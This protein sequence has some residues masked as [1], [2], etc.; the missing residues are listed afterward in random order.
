[1]N[2]S[3]PP[4]EQ[5]HQKLAT[6]VVAAEL[7]QSGDMVTVSGG[8][9]QPFAFLAALSR[10]RDLRRVTV[11]SAMSLL[12]ADL[13][14][15]QF[16]AAASGEAIER[17]VR[18]ASFCVGPGTREGVVSGV[19]DFVPMSLQNL[20][21]ALHDRRLDVVVIGSSGMD[22]EGNF[23]LGCNVDWM[24]EL[25]TSANLAETLVVVEVNS[26]LPRT[27]GTTTFPLRIVDRIVEAPRTPVDLPVGPPLPEAQAVGGFLNA[28]VPDG[29]TLQFG[30]GDLVSQSASLLD[31]KRDLGLHSNLISDVALFLSERGA[32]TG[33]KKKHLPG[34]WVGS[35][36]LGSRKLYEFADDSPVLALHS[37]E[38]VAHPVNI[39]RNDKVVSITQGVRVDLAGQVA[40]QTALMEF[41]SHPG[42]Q[43]V[44]HS[45][46]AA[47]PGGA[48]IV[49][50][51][52][53][54]ASGKVSNVVD[55]LPPRATVGIPRDDVDVI[56][57]EHG[58]ARLRGKTLPERAL[59]MISVAHP[60]SRDAL[61][62]RARKAG[63]L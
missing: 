59:A 53:A 42:V 3:I 47:S 38:F 61:A 57:T 44:F 34:R 26:E 15:R 56:V 55:T 48:G 4:R 33:K 43:R 37:C 31:G 32:L 39:L 62:A 46:A 60:D 10:R 45:A 12:P 51:P 14:V 23:N 25:I 7:V 35:F 8:S 27:M 54:S 63:L 5:Y 13:L 22:E 29:A 50:M 11:T 49:V 20:G 28:L 6:P 58:I 17:E 41:S 52:S 1:M 9:M 21:R 2:M 24:P 30:I 18:W 36:L 16:A 40:T 19:V